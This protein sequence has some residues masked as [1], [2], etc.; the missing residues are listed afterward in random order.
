[1]IDYV[2]LVCD[3]CG[4]VFN[5]NKTKVSKNNFC[6][7]SCYRKWLKINYKKFP[8]TSGSMN[9]RWKPGIDR[10]RTCEWCGEKYSVD[11]YESAKNTKK[12]CGEKCRREWYAKVWSQKEEWK[13]DR[14]NWAISLL[15][16]GEINTN[17]G[18]QL[19]VN[20]MLNELEIFSTR[21]KEYPHFTVDNYLDEKNLIIEVMGTYWHCD[22]RKYSKEINYQSQMNRIR[23]DKIKRSCLKNS[24]GIDV[25]YLW[26]Y[27]IDNNPELCKCLIREYFKNNGV[28]PNYHSMNYEIDLNKRLNLKNSIISPYMDW[29]IDD[30][31][32][33]FD[34]KEKNK[35]S[36]KQLDK[37][38]QYPC[39]MCGKECEELISHHVK[40]KNHFCSVSCFK[41]WVATP[42]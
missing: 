40:K 23:M 27:D 11:A 19:S 24:Y 6:S 36:K 9:P 18:I 31:N 33:I 10:E 15:K 35:F 4:N 37:W 22:I 21:E 28:L 12:F 29:D 20:S 26:E 32:K 1:M 16:S 34:I 3:G 7:L 41:K 17:T 2:E 8:D 5:R 25:L 38:I 39:D 13:Q 42:K 30:L 14:K